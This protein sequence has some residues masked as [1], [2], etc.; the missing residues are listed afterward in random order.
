M[1]LT[2]LYPI[3][4][5]IAFAIFVSWRIFF[6]KPAIEKTSCDGAIDQQ[7][8]FYNELE[9]LEYDALA[10]KIDPETYTFER[11][12]LLQKIAELKG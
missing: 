9:Q 7:E 1:T 10:G 4:V 12:K 5:S 8:L 3:I 11:E 2:N 6:V